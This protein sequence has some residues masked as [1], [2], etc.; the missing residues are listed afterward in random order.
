[1]TYKTPGIYTEDI[2]SFPPTITEVETAIPVFIGYTEKTE[3]QGASLINKPVELQSLEEYRETFGGAVAQ[4]FVVE[5]E[6]KSSN[7]PKTL[8]FDKKENPY[9]MDPAMALFYANGGGRCYVV[10][11]GTYT[12]TLKR[13][14][15]EAGLEA[16]RRV[17]EITLVIIPEAV[18]L[19]ANDQYTLY[20]R[21]LDHCS[22]FNNRFAIFDVRP[23]DLDAFG[24]RNGI[25]THGLSYGAAYYPH[26]QTSLL[27]TYQEKG[28][29]FKNSILDGKN[30][31]QLIRF[32][33]VLDRNNELNK[34]KNR[35]AEIRDGFEKEHSL[36]QL[37]KV[38][39]EMK[40]GLKLVSESVKLVQ[41]AVDFKDALDA[42]EQWI[43]EA[44]NLSHDGRVGAPG[45]QKQIEKLWNALVD[46]DGF[47][48][49]ALTTVSAKI[50]K[51][52]GTELGFDQ[53]AKEKFQELFTDRFLGEVYDLLRKKYRLMPPSPALAGI[54]AQVDTGRGVWKAPANVPIEGIIAPAVRLTLDQ[55]NNLNEHQT[56]KSVNAIRAF[57]GRGTLVWGARTLEGNSNEWRYIPVRRFFN[58]VEKSCKQATFQF[59]FEP[60]NAQTWMKVKAMLDNYLRAQWRAGALMGKETD[61]AFFVKVG[62]GETMTQEDVNNGRMIIEIGMAAVRPAEFIILR[63]SHKMLEN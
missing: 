62:L 60:N 5:L 21:I 55:N 17:E 56:G 39:Q 34:V 37:R 52:T 24:F 59:V 63:F 23:D 51:E 45:H 15:F 11:I 28:I 6:E 9:L 27:Y 10:S 44:K 18:K 7:L 49:P 57:T 38:L 47:G 30:L 22:R 25:G 58:V 33:S 1:M 50:V 31:E 2:S 36:W 43:E 41:R 26:L 35:I 54:Y 4:T 46:D 3:I 13:S 42:V 8:V 48:F 20:D 14:D 40:T 61:E 19:E 12:N 29:K 32:R 16:T 53:N